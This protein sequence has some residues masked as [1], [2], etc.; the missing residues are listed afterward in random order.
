[1]AAVNFYSKMAIAN[2]Q[3]LNM[4]RSEFVPFTMT[5]FYAFLVTYIIWILPSTCMYVSK[6]AVEY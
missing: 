5:W 1:M 6:V 4:P 3:I 2:M